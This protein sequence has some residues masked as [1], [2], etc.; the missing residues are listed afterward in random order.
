MPASTM[1]TMSNEKATSVEPNGSNGSNASQSPPASTDSGNKKRG[2]SS[3]GLDSNGNPK[4]VKRRAAKACAACRAR[5]VR[6]D[7]MQRYHVTPEGTVTCSNCTMDGITCVIE[8]SKRRKKNLNGQSV[9]SEPQPNTNGITQ[10]WRNGLVNPSDI[11]NPE[12][13]RWSGSVVS[14]EG[15]DY[16]SHVP[17]AIYQNV[18]KQINK[19]EIL[20]RAGYIHQTPQYDMDTIHSLLTSAAPSGDRTRSRVED[21]PSMSMPPVPMLKH[22]LPDY[23]KPLPQRMTSVDIDYLF[24]KGALS[25]P[26][27]AVRNALLRSYLEYVHPYMPL[28]EIH[29]LLQIIDD[30]TGESG[31]ISLLLFQAIMF[32]GTAFV[33]ME[34][35]RAAGY[36]N[37]KTARKAFFQK[38]RVLYDFDYE[39]DRVSLVQSLL[40]MTYWY[41][42]PDDQKDTWHWMGV[43]ISLAHT[44]GLHRDPSK[45]NMEPN[46]KKLWKRIWWSCFMRDRLVALGM[47]RPTRVK[48]EDYDVPM[49]TEADFEIRPL[50]ESNSIIPADCSLARDVDAQRDLAQM[51]IAKAKLCLCVSQVLSAQYSVL[52]KHQGMQSL[53][54]N[55]R[56]NVMLIPKKLDQTDEVKRCDVELMKWFSE[57]PECCQYSNEMPDGNSGPPLFVQRSLLHM[58]YLTTLSALHRPQVL[59]SAATPQPDS[60]RELQDMSRKKVREASREITRISSDL[61]TRDLEKYLP[62]TGVTV[63]LPAI[64]IHLLDIKSCNDEARQAAMDGFCECMRVLEK[65]RDNYSSADF[66]TQF[67]E[68]AIRKADIDLVIGNSGKSNHIRE[69]NVQAMLGSEKIR[70]L[71]D[72]SRQAAMRHTP[73]L[74]EVQDA[75]GSIDVGMG[76]VMSTERDQVHNAISAHTPPDSD[77][78][79][80]FDANDN[81]KNDFHNM[82]PVDLNMAGF[83]NPP[84]DL[85]M[86]DFINF[87]TGNEMLFDDGWHGESGGI[88]MDMG[89]DWVDQSRNWSRM[90]TPMLEGDMFDNVNVSAGTSSEVDIRA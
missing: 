21:S 8:E 42:T 58:V 20:R 56:S 18:N 82:N 65:L 7:V 37:R 1:S 2:T 16:T 77:T 89:M 15:E 41:E 17:H 23:L 13:R 27:V 73:P 83:D 35:L 11:S 24:A 29:D 59:P 68:A 79:T 26:D 19:G 62:T 49:L 46:K 76:Y 57:L 67:L 72:R 31:R 39:I 10:A 84:M 61:H 66:A 69:E 22:V 54:G 25:L 78:H 9:A 32:A 5:K 38:A 86:T 14:N 4:P 85:N 6:C 63:L 50:A 75:S 80:N 81:L 87:D 12:A 34:F 51:C 43:A 30:G 53:E 36:S 60:S 3:A 55:T 28:I 45:A 52:V 88:I 33:D 70:E 90:G 44:I 71:R 40:L 74:S 48:D 64:I 47:R